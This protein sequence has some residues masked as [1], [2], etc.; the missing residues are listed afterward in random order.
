MNFDAVLDELI[1]LLEA[2]D[3]QVRREPLVESRGGLCR[4][5]G[6]QVLFIDTNADAL[7]SAALCAQTLCRVM[8]ISGIYLRPNLRQFIESAVCSDARD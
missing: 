3:V 4:I 2:G 1:G 5:G 6:R 8:D 7:Q